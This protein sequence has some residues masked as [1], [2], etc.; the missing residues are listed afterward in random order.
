MKG[1]LNGIVEPVLHNLSYELRFAID[2]SY[3]FVDSSAQPEPTISTT[4]IIII[5]TII[6]FVSIIMIITV[7]FLGQ[8]W[9]DFRLT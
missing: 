8:L 5:I 9:L 6:I 3:D 7:I 4:I 1:P 2:A